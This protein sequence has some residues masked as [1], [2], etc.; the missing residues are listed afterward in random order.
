MPK[1]SV[2]GAVKASLWYSHI[3]SPRLRA[4]W[5]LPTEVLPTHHPP[6]SLISSSLP[7][8][9]IAELRSRLYGRRGAVESDEHEQTDYRRKFLPLGP[10]KGSTA[11]RVGHPEP[12]MPAHYHDHRNEIV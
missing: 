1:A 2:V 3:A 10:V 6:N 4:R 11:I 9:H 7:A 5:S 8:S 12:E